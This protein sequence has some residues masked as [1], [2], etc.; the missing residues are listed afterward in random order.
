MRHGKPRNLIGLPIEARLRVL[1]TLLTKLIEED[2]IHTTPAKAQALSFLANGI[3]RDAK[4]NS[5]ESR[6][7]IFNLIKKKELAIKVFGEIKSRYAELPAD[8]PFVRIWR[9][10]NDRHLTHQPPAAILEYVGAP[11]DIK[12]T[13]MLFA[14]ER[15]LTVPEGVN[16]AMQPDPHLR[17][18]AA[19]ERSE[20]E[21]SLLGKALWIEKIGPVS[22]NKV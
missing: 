17:L 8:G 18:K 5:P 13:L 10:G 20:P 22:V 21:P 15:G 2:R 14:K 11:F 7:R 4:E 16:F 19:A 6:E 1:R 3:V 12:E 9:N